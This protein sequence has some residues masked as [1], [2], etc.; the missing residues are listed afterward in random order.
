MAG[1][2]RRVDTADDRGG[3][4]T[5]VKD[6]GRVKKSKPVVESK[7]KPKKPQKKV[8][9]SDDDDDDDDEQV[10]QEDVDMGDASSESEEDTTQDQK[11]KA[12][13][14]NTDNSKQANGTGDGAAPVK[15]GTSS[16]ESRAKQKALAQERKA[17]K[18]NSDI[19]AR[20]KKLWERL[21]RKSHV[22]LEERK[23]L[24]A[25][26]YSIITGRVKEFVFKHDSVRV[27]QTALKYASPQ[28]RKDVATELKGDYRSLAESKYA[29]FL[30][31]KLLVHGDS[32]IR[33]M[34]VPEFY[35]HVRRLMRHPEASW[36][37][38]DIYRTVAT[39]AQRAMLL[40][41]WYGAEFVIFRNADGA[42]ETADLA[43][44]IAK[45]PEKRGPIMRY[46]QEFINHLVQKKFTGFTMLHDAML[47]YFL[48]TTPGSEE[49]TE[50][51]ELIKGD[52]AG[53]LAKNLAFTKSGSRLVSLCFA[54]SNAKD[55]K[56]LLRMYRDT[57]KML[58]GDMNG[59][60]VLL[61]AY[62][63]IDDTKLSSKSIFPEL[64]NQASTVEARHEEL[65]LQVTD[66]T[67][68]IP[69]LY[70]FAED[71]TRWLVTDSDHKKILDEVLAIRSETSKKD[72][73]TRRQELIKVASPTLLEFIAA[74][75]DS[76]VE[77]S[78]GCQFI[79]EVLFSADGDKT[80]ALAAIAATPTSKPEALETSAAGRMLK[81]LVQGGRFN[82][83]TKCVDKVQPPLNFHGLLYEHIAGDVMA[84][85][86][87]ANPFVILALVEA[88]DF[89]KRDELVK[90]LKGQQ[91]V[92][93]E[94]AA[95]E[96]A[97]KGEKR[98][99]VTSAAKLLLEK[100][101]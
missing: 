85:V 10:E 43:E 69:I 71:T 16:K 89:E 40:R 12:Q 18:P 81:A 21:R 93:A 80:A 3:K 13:T 7:P 28:Q 88:E 4:R 63:V 31:G 22:P 77:S 30:I 74:S 46:L 52:E 33:D 61:T 32:E 50:L 20:S 66:L 92:L 79:T 65:L 97:K 45:N 24:V 5:K 78:F 67:A 83:K 23:T 19:I 36:I 56:L 91:K 14:K 25:E 15:S 41:E 99:P 72:P 47:Q 39:A 55:R 54:Y 44:I 84:W 90:T 11:S 70:P 51:I 87:G 17:A 8:E 59:Q 1:I 6:G 62:E 86:T 27:I 101:G 95:K 82:S 9:S 96:P 57:I 64:L 29:K 75:A 42:P 26:L 2:K 94:L 58:A 53:D 38:D 48:N 76:L 100:I 73:N 35:G 68:R 34:I 37:V 49:A 60:I 98:G